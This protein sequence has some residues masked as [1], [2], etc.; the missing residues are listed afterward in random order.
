MKSAC[1]ENWPIDASATSRPPATGYWIAISIDGTA[2]GCE[3][4]QRPAVEY[5]MWLLWS[6]LSRCL[7]SQQSGK[8]TWRRRLFPCSSGHVGTEL[9]GRTF[10]L[11]PQ[12][13]K[14]IR[15]LCGVIAFEL[16]AIIISPG[17]KAR[18]RCRVRRRYQTVALTKGVGWFLTRSVGA[19]YPAV[20]SAR[21]Q[22][23]PALSSDRGVE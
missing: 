18:T 22:V 1:P 10:T 6:A 3:V 5:A 17:G 20:S 16:P 15:R 21:W 14:V 13:Q 12:S 4:G 19:Q 23:V 2:T 8:R 7:P 9:E 11:S